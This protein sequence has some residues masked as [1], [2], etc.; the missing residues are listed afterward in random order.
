MLEEKLILIA[1]RQPRSDT[2]EGIE[3]GDDKLRGESLTDI[4]EKYF[5]R[6][7]FKGDFRLSPSTGTLYAILSE[8]K[9]REKK[10]SIYGDE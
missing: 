1:K 7:M 3:L 8:E 4:L 2:W 9:P 5:Q 6:T 10:L